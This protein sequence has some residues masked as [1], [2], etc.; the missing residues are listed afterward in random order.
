MSNSRFSRALGTALFLSCLWACGAS[1]H[2]TTWQDPG[3]T[4]E[5]FGKILVMAMLPSLD[6][7]KIVEER[8]VQKLQDKGA[9]GV[10]SLSLFPPGVE[11]TPEEFEARLAELGVDA[12]L[13]IKLVG[14]DSVKRYVP[15]VTYYDSYVSGYAT[16]TVQK[17][18][19]GYVETYGRIYQTVATLYQG[20]SDRLVWRGDS[21]TDYYGDLGASVEAY[22]GSVVG[23]LAKAGLLRKR[24]PG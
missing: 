24:P 22:A 21:E 10:G 18:D 20:E 1:T 12:V 16:R 6:S 5:G 23:S 3:Y 14:A 17:S 2:I 11:S 13:M 15:E 4:G 8:M 7:Q 9:D 19:G